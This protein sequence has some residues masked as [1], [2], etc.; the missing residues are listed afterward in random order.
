MN[1]ILKITMACF[2]STLS[3]KNVC[4]GSEKI[5][6]KRIIIAESEGHFYFF[7]LGFYDFYS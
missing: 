7:L 5:K 1:N 6:K 2:K 4:D 3:F